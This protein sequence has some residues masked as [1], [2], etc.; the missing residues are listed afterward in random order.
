M[1][2]L[3]VELIRLIFEFCDGPSVRSLRLVSSFLAQVGYDYLIAAHFYGLAY[4][5]HVKRL[6]A[7]ACHERLRGSISVIT[8]N[9]SP[10]AVHHQDLERQSADLPPFHTQAALLEEA[11]AALPNLQEL[12]ITYTKPP[13]PLSRTGEASPTVAH[14]PRRVCDRDRALARLTLNALITAL[15][16]THLTA[17]TLDGVPLELFRQAEDRRHWF[18]CAR[19][20]LAHLTRLDLAV[21]PPASLYPSARFRAVNGL[22]RVLQFTG[23]RLRRL[24]L[25]A[26]PAHA[27]REKFA[28]CFD[29]LLGGQGF[30]WP[31]LEELVLEGLSLAEADLRGFLVRHGATLRR[32][33]LGGRGL[34]KAGEASVG[35]IHL[36]EGMFRALFA[37]LRGRLPVLERFHMEGD[38]GAVDAAAAATLGTARARGLMQ[39]RAVAAED[40]AE[41][42]PA[43]QSL[44]EGQGRRMLDSVELERYLVRG[45]DFPRLVTR[46]D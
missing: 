37:G 39:F 17:L 13:R 6:H 21:D 3:P 10:L 33:R 23:P 18:G 14:S 7:I 9:F 12:E 32:L 46:E 28:L 5:N 40:W 19:A 26:R 34:A 44:G 31:C 11:L 1:D 22:G 35:G 27:P 42:V 8:F 41:L 4:R 36:H 2:T 29:A 30:V 25:R 43:E 15:R 20:P 24:A 45:G 38:F 16:P